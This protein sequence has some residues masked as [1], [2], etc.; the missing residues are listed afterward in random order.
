MIRR[1]A[2][3]LNHIDR[4]RLWTKRALVESIWRIEAKLIRESLSTWP[5]PLSQDEN[6]N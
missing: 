5:F 2:S 1:N 3:L 6:A 4:A